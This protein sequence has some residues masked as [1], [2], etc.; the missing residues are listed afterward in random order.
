MRNRQRQEV[1]FLRS[2]L[3]RKSHNNLS[4]AYPQAMHR[5]STANSLQN[6]LSQ[7]NT[8]DIVRPIHSFPISCVPI[9]TASRTTRGCSKLPRYVGLL[10]KKR[11]NTP[12]SRAGIMGRPRASTSPQGSNNSGARHRVKVT[13]SRAS[14]TQDTQE[15]QY[16]RPSR[17]A[18]LEERG[19]QRHGANPFV[20]RPNSLPSF[21]PARTRNG[22]CTVSC[23]FSCRWVGTRY[24]VRHLSDAV[25]NT[26]GSKQQIAVH[27]RHIKAAA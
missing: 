11:H 22:F 17:K 25:P 23:V 5:D 18:G 21:S 19:M 3:C 16:H 1:T 4:P 10:S 13:K 15:Q 26:A 27:R 8:P 12:A 7:K 2:K 20:L 24:C 14:T 9:G 6:P